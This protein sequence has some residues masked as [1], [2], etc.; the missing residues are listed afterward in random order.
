MTSYYN[1]TYDPD[2]LT[3]YKWA[4]QASLCHKWCCEERSEGNN[5]FP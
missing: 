2:E 4:R 3:H 5:G 1:S